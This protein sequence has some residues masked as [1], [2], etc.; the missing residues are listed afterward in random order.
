LSNF[1]RARVV[2]ALFSL[3]KDRIC[4]TPEIM[5]EYAAGVV[6]AGLP[7]FKSDVPASLYQQNT[8]TTIDYAYDPLYRL[9]ETNYSTGDYYHYTLRQAHIVPMSFG[10]AAPTT[11]LATA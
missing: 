10:R 7:Q 1:A 5:A 4:S 6:A 11:P 3:W 2:P 9:T 8:T